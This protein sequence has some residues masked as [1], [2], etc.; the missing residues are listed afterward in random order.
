M[1][2]T[3]F[4]ALL[5][6]DMKPFYNG[7]TEQVVAWIRVNLIEDTKSVLVAVGKTMEVLSVKEYLQKY[8]H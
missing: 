7:T 3:Y 4:D 8:G 6:E 2:G 1:A 5:T